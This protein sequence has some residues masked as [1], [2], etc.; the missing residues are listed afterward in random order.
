MGVMETVRVQLS[1][2][3]DQA[4][5]AFS[6]HYRAGGTE[7]AMGGLAGTGK[8]T[9]INELR[10]QR[11]DAGLDTVFAAPTAKACAVLRRKGVPAI[12]IHSAIYN[13]R[14]AHVVD[15]EQ[16]QRQELRFDAK[17]RGEA[18]T[19]KKLVVV[20]ET[21]MVTTQ[22]ADDL[23]ARAA[24]IFWVGDH[25]QLAPVGNDPGIMRNLNVKLERIH[26][27]AEHS[28]ILQLAHAIRQGASLSGYARTVVRSPDVTFVEVY[29]GYGLAMAMIEHKADVAIV[30]RNET[31]ATCNIAYRRHM[32]WNDLVVPGE[33]VVGLKNSYVTNLVNGEI[34][35]VVSVGQETDVYVTLV[36]EDAIGDKMTVRCWRGCFGKA[37]P[38]LL[39]M[40]A[41]SRADTGLC[42]VDYAIALTCHKAQGSEWPRALVYD[43][44][45]DRAGWDPKRWAYTAATRAKD[46]LIVAG[47]V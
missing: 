16:G 12:T 3:Q 14:G 5:N 34:Y 42:F 25:G 40:D 21:S 17:R 23:R 30:A 32:K 4:I 43:E 6:N 7:F 20:D 45:V 29:N 15:D 31:R 18:H 28:T 47:G 8:S 46:H 33:R 44:K 9:V 38:D 37:K 19:E 13:F 11:E 35:T 22:M 26:R 24:S 41:F 2:D 1:E 27:Q 39:A 36:L 10:L